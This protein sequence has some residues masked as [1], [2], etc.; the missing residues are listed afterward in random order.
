MPRRLSPARSASMFVRVWDT[1]DHATSR[2]DTLAG[3]IARPQAVGVQLD[4]PELYT[5]FD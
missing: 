4:S 2:T 1:E 3:I 5:S